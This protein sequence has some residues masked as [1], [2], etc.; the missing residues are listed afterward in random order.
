[1]VAYYIATGYYN[2]AMYEARLQLHIDSIIDEIFNYKVKNKRELK[3][4][5]R[6]LLKI[7]YG[8]YIYDEDP[9]DFK[10]VKYKI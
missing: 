8:L 9:L 7:K 5:I 10:K 2:S 3:R 6:K 1:M 4:N